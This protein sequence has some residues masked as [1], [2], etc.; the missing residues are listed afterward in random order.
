MRTIR[1]MDSVPGYYHYS[2]I[3]TTIQEAIAE[4]LDRSEN[5]DEDLQKQLS[6]ITATWGLKYWER[7]LGLGT[8]ENE[9]YEDRRS[10]VLSR[11]RGVGNFSASLIKSV[12]EAYSGGEVEVTAFKKNL[13][14]SQ[15]RLIG[16]ASEVIEEKDYEVSIDFTGGFDLFL[17]ENT[18]VKRNTTYT[19][20]IKKIVLG[21][22]VQFSIR[23]ASG[24][25]IAN[26]GTGDT[27]TFNS[28]NNDEVSL[29]FI[30]ADSS[31]GGKATIYDWQLEE[32]NQAT[33]FEPRR[34]FMIGIRFI[35]ARGIPSQLE[36]LKA[37]IENI[38][39]AH[40]GT[41]YSFSFLVWD[42]LDQGN[43]T[44]DQIDPRN[45]TWE[46]FEVWRP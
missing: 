4:D 24:N 22:D 37:Q 30:R 17:A 3:F 31:T 12:A 38:I 43:V 23:G 20:S 27:L 45:M 8:N 32:G 11:W 1:M 25:W 2:K 10:R 41:E 39:H 28:G 46:E 7:T 18:K 19:A 14:R 21:N 33:R 9:S 13:A 16:N 35:G 40:L 6:I 44:W 5:N 26:A 36:D 42:E 29:R 15:A 34:E